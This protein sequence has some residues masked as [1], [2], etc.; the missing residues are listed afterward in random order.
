MKCLLVSDLHYTLKQLDWVA[1]VAAYFDVVVIAGDHLDPSS[2]VAAQ[3]QIVRHPESIC[4][5]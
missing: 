1:R 2:T 3:V 4:E 5:A